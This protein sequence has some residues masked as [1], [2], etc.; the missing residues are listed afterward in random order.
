MGVLSFHFLWLG[1]YNATNLYDLYKGIIDNEKT[2]HRYYS[3]LN[4]FRC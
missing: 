1:G 3:A 2:D 4:D